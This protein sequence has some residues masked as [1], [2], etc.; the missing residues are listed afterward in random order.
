MQMMSKDTSRLGFHYFAD[1]LHYRE[2][3]LNIWLPELKRLGAAWLTLLAPCARAIP[4]FFLNGLLAAGI[5]PIL[6]LP[7][8]LVDPVEKDELSPLFRIYARWGVRYL[9]LFDRPNHRAAWSAGS[10]VQEELVERFLDLYIPLAEIAHTEGL[11][12]VFPPLEPGGDY[13]DLA[14]L[15]MAL[16]GLARR[17]RGN[18]LEELVLG[19]YAWVNARP[20]DWGTGG[21]DRWPGAR[22]YFT[23]PGVQD[24]LGF[25]IFDWYEDILREELGKPLPILLLRAGALPKEFPDVDKESALKHGQVNLAIAQLLAGDE[26]GYEPIPEQIQACN[27]WLLASEPGNKYSPHAWFQPDGSRLPVVEL[28]RQWVGAQPWEIEAQ[29]DSEVSNGQGD[30]EMPPQVDEDE[31]STATEEHQSTPPDNPDPPQVKTTHIEP[32]RHP[33]NHYI[34]LPLYAWGAGEWDL[35]VIKPMMKDTHPTVGFSLA[36]A[37]LAR[38]VT[39]VG[40]PGAITDETLEMLR[41]AGSRVERLFPDGTLIAT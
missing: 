11:V 24:H 33:I 20:L 21:R 26:A 1:T 36:E 22:P 35:E 2:H 41:E 38:R 28:F 3:D 4:E 9:A 15:Q 14:F 5:Q 12:P 31:Y 32:G 8:S 39:V 25:R 19:A 10:W 29:G 13:W 16:R 30:D 6:H 18:W 37:R 7:L 40:G 17:Q 34:L 23:P 27:F